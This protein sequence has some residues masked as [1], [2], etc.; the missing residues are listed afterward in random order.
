MSIAFTKLDHASLLVRN[1]EQAQAFYVDL[2]E[3]KID[4][5]RPIMS[6]RGLWLL[7]GDESIHLLELPSDDPIDGR[8]E[9]VGLDRHIAL[10]VENL[11]ALRQRLESVNISYTRSRSGRQ[12]IFFRDPDGNGLEVIQS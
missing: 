8:P 3:L 11:D 1:L 6:F 4:T 7:V 10:R 12:A 2:L 5:R 9:H